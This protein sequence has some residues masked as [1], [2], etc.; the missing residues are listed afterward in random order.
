MRLA[1]IAAAAVAAASIASASTEVYRSGDATGFFVPFNVNTPAGTLYGDSGWFGTGSDAPVALESITLGLATFANS[2]V[3]DG[4]TDLVFTLNDGDPS[5][6]VFGT[7]ATLFSTTITDVTLPAANG[8]DPTYFEITIP[9]NGTMTLGGFNNVGF[10]LGVSNFNY[11]G[12]FGFQNSGQFNYLGF[13]TGNA[14]EFTPGSGW[15]LFS[16]GPSFPSDSANFRM[17]VTVPEPAT[18]AGL[19]G[20]ATLLLRRR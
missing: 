15:S 11:E 9:L 3:E 17:V 10:S 20:A 4:K 13:L 1:L 16:F 8:D 18:L 14:S 2:P 5:G 19:F 6:L 7:A 12:S